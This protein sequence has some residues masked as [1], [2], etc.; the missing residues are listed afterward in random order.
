MCCDVVCEEPEPCLE[1]LICRQ[2]ANGTLVLQWIINAAIGQDCCEEYTVTYNGNP[3]ATLPA[4]VNTFTVDPCRSGVYCVECVKPDGT[5][6]RV[7]CDVECEE[8]DPCSVD[9]ACQATDG[10]V[11]I[12]WFYSDPTAPCC[13]LVESYHEG[14][15]I[16]TVPGGQTSVFIDECRDGQWCVRC[17]RLD[18][19]PGPRICCRVICPQERVNQLPNDCN[20]DGS[21]DL[22]DAICLLVHLFLGGPAPCG[23]TA[24][25]MT[26]FDANVDNSADVSD[27]LYLLQYLFLGGPPPVLGTDCIFIPTCPDVCTTP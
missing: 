27:A 22:G 1:D 6:E 14:V 12:E 26:L 8:P 7:C 16:T 20:Q 3:I 5:V 18:G 15:L 21:L 13:E 2:T 10:G 17:I 25:N 11:L 4:G 24:G 19:T 9:V 23:S